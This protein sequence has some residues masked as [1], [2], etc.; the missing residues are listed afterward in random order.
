MPLDVWFPETARTEP[1]VFHLML[2]A[3]WAC[4]K[5]GNGSA[6]ELRSRGRL[7]AVEEGIVDAMLDANLV[8]QHEEESGGSEGRP[9]QAARGAVLLSRARHSWR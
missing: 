2:E 3:I 8:W 9:R 7:T 4:S 5:R 6:Q 1:L